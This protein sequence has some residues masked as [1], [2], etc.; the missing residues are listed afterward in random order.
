MARLEGLVRGLL[1]GDPAPTATVEQL[2]RADRV[3]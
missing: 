2:S 3:A 1:A